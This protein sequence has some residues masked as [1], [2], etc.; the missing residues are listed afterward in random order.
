MSTSSGN[1]APFIFHCAL[2]SCTHRNRGWK[3]SHSVEALLFALSGAWEAVRPPPGLLNALR[4][5]A[6]R[7]AS[8]CLRGWKR[9]NKSARHF[10]GDINGDDGT[11]GSGGGGGSDSGSGRHFDSLGVGVDG[12]G[13]GDGDSRANGGDCGE[14]SDRGSAPAKSSSRSA[15]CW[16]RAQKS[17]LF[18]SFKVGPW[19]RGAFSFWSFLGRGDGAGRFYTPVEQGIGWGC[20][21]GFRCRNRSL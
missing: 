18:W 21:M 2:L 20:R 15:G 8:C 13:D 16:R 12:G 1:I 11:G 5:G 14:N 7:V 19:G 4:S 9:S 6:R 10:N 3:A 17:P